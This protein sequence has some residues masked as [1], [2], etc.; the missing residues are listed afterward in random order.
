MVQ[1][2]LTSSVIQKWKEVLL[3]GSDHSEQGDAKGNLVPGNDTV[4]SIALN[5]YSDM[6]RQKA[7]IDPPVELHK[8]YRLLDDSQKQF[9]TERA[10]EIPDK[11]I[12]LDLQIRKHPGFCRT[13][14][15][16]DDEIKK[17]ALH[18]CHNIR[19]LKKTRA[20]IRRQAG[21]AK[22][23]HPKHF[24]FYL[25]L[26]YLIPVELK[27]AGYEV[28]RKAENAE[29]SE[30]M[31]NRIAM[32]IHSRYLSQLKKTGSPGIENGAGS[33]VNVQAG[34]ENPVRTSFDKLPDEIKFSNIDNA[35]HIPAKLLAVGYKIKPAGKGFKPVALH[36]SEKEIET[37]A[38]IEH[39]RWSW[40]KRLHGWIWGKKRDYEAKIHPG[41]LPY[42]KLKEGEKDKDRE[43]VRLIPSLLKDIGYV[44]YPVNPEKLRNLTYA[45]R[46]ANSIQKIL[47]ETNTLNNRIRSQVKV[48]R[49]L[50]EM[51]EMRNR[52][53]EEAITEIEESY[54]Y[55]RHIQ[56]TFLPDNLLVREMFPQS[57]ILYCPKDI[58]SGDFYFFSRQN[59]LLVFA[60]ADCTGHGIPGALLT[61]IGYGILDQA[62][63]E[64]N[65]TDPAEILH[66]LYS[67]LHRFLRNEEGTGVP[68][69]M[70]IVLCTL[71]TQSYT[72]KY[73]S[74]GN[75]FYRISGKKLYEY[76]ANSIAER[77]ISDG[78]CTFKTSSLKVRKGDILYLFSDGFIHQFGGQNHK[79]YQTT[80]FKPFLMNICT[81]PMPEQAD[82]LFEE[83]EAWRKVNN[84]VQTDDILIT[85]LTI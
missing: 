25:E 51:I 74:V 58:V 67:R 8:E 6:C 13:C 14:I 41:L 17:L 20:G 1:K 60:V 57:F 26:N 24:R 70:D 78:Q 5:L 80:R 27:K 49:E 44:A 59:N 84:E 72:L 35:Y 85:G 22:D 64:V 21:E 79:K 61:T 30:R 23:P 3:P 19:G 77:C 42:D 10:I 38:E 7:F 18:D 50:E 54:N 48:P 75:A 2:P 76:A 32:A 62:V 68:D 83:F 52:K 73:S 40:D 9:W 66:H 53:V 28:I 36:L 16:T 15:I 46:P 33:F 34:N 56:E 55:A 63:N 12:M 65:L 31:V 29:I 47:D 71:D 37:M 45:L 11:L 82:L 4:R 69:D 81:S 39:M 43:L